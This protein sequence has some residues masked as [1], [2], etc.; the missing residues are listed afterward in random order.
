MKE[1]WL[2]SSLGASPAATAPVVRCG[3]GVQ[4]RRTEQNRTEQNSLNEKLGLASD[5]GMCCDVNGGRGLAFTTASGRANHD[6]S[7]TCQVWAQ[8]GVPRGHEGCCKHA[9]VPVQ[10]NQ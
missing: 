6:I 4:T 5:R 10:G 9:L 2:C 7:K 8:L 1:L 3:D